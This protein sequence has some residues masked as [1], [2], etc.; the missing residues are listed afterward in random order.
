M[1]RV[2]IDTDIFVRYL[3]YPKDRET[4]I[5]SKFV[6]L[7]RDSKIAG[8]TSIFNV[9]EVCGVLSFNYSEQDLINLYTDFCQHF[10]LKVLFPADKDG[11][12]QYNFF[13]IF[14]LMIKKCSL[15]DAETSYVVSRFEDH[16]SAF[17]SWN[18]IHYKGR[19]VGPV[20]TPKEYLEK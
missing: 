13:E 18:S 9:L 5:N 2:F 20:L 4:K 1:K 14:S 19:I 15:G 11:N 6:K 3:R 12:L 8:V 7:V 17:V 16:I 10:N